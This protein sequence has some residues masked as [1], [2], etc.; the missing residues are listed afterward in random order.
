MKTFNVVMYCFY[1]KRVIKFM[2][3]HVQYVTPMARILMKSCKA[4]SYILANIEYSGK[5]RQIN[6][7]GLI[8]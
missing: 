6:Q 3:R 4:Y 5:G 2:F 7:A 8:S 1:T